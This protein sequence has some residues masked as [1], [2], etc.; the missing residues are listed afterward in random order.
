MLGG[1]Q[2][3]RTVATKVEHGKPGVMIPRSLDTAKFWKVLESCMAIAD[4][5]TGYAKI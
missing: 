3:G 2:E 1:T 4:K 5:K